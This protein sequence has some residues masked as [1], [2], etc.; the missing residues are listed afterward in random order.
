MLNLQTAVRRAAVFL[1]RW[2]WVWL[3]LAA[4][5]LL[6]PSPSRTPALL[7]VPG[8]WIIAW[9]TRRESLPRTP[10]NGTLLLLS[11]MVL[12]SLYATYSIAVSLPKVAGMVLGLGAFYAIVR[13]GQSPRGWCLSLCA[14]LAIGVGMAG[15]GLLGTRWLFKVSFLT[16]IVSRLPAR[17]TGLPGA[18]E[19]LSANE[20]AGALLW[21][22][23]VLITLSAWTLIQKRELQ[24]MVGRARAMGLTI[25]TVGVTLFV[26]G[27]LMLTQSRSGYIG[28]AFGGLML[29]LFALPSRWR[30]FAEAGLAILVVLVVILVSTQGAQYVMHGLLGGAAADNPALSLDTLEG[31]V[32]V[33]SRAL[34]GI[35]DFP[36]TGMGMNTFRRVV[37]VLYPLFLVG[38][39]FDVAHAHNEFLQAALD[40]GIPGLIAFLALYISAFW[41]LREIWRSAD[42]VLPIADS[43]WPVSAPDTLFAALL[44]SPAALRA[45]VLGFG[46]GLFAHMVY[47]MTDA[48]AL[49]AKPGVLFWMLL[50][51]VVA[52]FEQA[53]SSQPETSSPL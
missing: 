51:L 45:L 31:R 49:G 26:A 8:L 30:K 9:L 23:S 6:F 25:S 20:L 16:P 47:G 2:H 42:R 32:E 5:F 50:G 10:L 27:V 18:E 34:Y 1:D 38:P 33:W 7:V 39:D 43:Q 4:P 21:I 17:I 28:F 11:L 24:A 52:L 44:F 19:G 46:G 22:V 53:R 15:F 13:S 48:V 12:V 3:I 37:H 29:A 14:F 41:M 40:L 35:Q 36:F